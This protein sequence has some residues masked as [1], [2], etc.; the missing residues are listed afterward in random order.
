MDS[1]VVMSLVI[2]IILHRTRLSMKKRGTKHQ[3]VVAM[4]AEN[5][6]SF[7][8][9]ETLIAKECFEQWLR[10]SASTEICHLHSDN[11]IFNAKLF[12]E[13]CKSK[14]QTQS[15]SGVG[16]PN[17]NALIKWSIQTIM[18]MTRTFIVH[19]SLHWRESGADNLALWGFAV[20]HADWLHNC[21]PNC[22]SGM[23]S[24]ELLTK[25]KANHPDLL[26]THVWGCPVYVL[27]PMLQ[28]GQK[29]PKWNCWF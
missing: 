2:R 11:G 20:K 15:F 29:I 14:F 18:Y 5:Q 13:D 8:A 27:N 21:I 19:V 25:S 7:G 1:I 16:A 28:D 12:M 24:F 10:D 4:E 26:R 22:L 3:E 6:V 23:T 17:Q 9:G